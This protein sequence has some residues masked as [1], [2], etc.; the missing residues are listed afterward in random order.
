MTP[1]GRFYHAVSTRPAPAL[2]RH[3]RRLGHHPG[4]LDRGD[5]SRR[6]SGSSRHP[7]LRQPDHAVDDVP[8][9]DRGHQG[10]LSRPLQSSTCSPA[11][12]RTCGLLS[13]RLDPERVG[14]FLDALVPVETVDGWFLCGPFGMVEGARGAARARGS[15][16]LTSTR[17]LPRR[18][19]GRPGVGRGRPAAGGATPHGDRRARRARDDVRHGADGDSVLDA[20]LRNAPTRPMPARA[21]C[22]V[23]AG[24]SS[25]TARC[26]WTAT[27]RWRTEEIEAG[28]VLA[29][30]SHPVTDE[31]DA[32]LRPVAR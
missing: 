32:R 25:S 21:G 19:R 14:R 6:G 30:Q 2:R 20:V 13:G 26:G 4:A 23:P 22:A 18:G 11:S 8:R 1:A 10:P 16:A 27:S 7:G 9:R 24:P 3:R 31:V 29:C 5:D 15:G 28:F 12:R 17:A